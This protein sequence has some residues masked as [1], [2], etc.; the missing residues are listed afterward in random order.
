MRKSM[1][2]S[3][4]AT[5]GLWLLTAA[6]LAALF[7]ATGC[8]VVIPPEDKSPR[9]V[10][11][12][13]TAWDTDVG[14]RRQGQRIAVNVASGWEGEGLFYDGPGRKIITAWIEEIKQAHPAFRYIYDNPEKEF[15]FSRTLSA[16][17]NHTGDWR[18]EEAEHLGGPRFRVN[19]HFDSRS[20]GMDNFSDFVR[21]YGEVFV[22]VNVEEEEI[23]EIYMEPEWF[24]LV[25]VDR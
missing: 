24:R 4:P 11:S 20:I 19:A 8:R 15:D 7:G 18:Y 22:D 23:I 21:V 12:S 14:Q 17:L 16:S 3:I 5:P 1:F 2:K 25:K 10:N 13:D 9:P 6:I